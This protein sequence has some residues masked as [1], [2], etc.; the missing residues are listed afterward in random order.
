MAEDDGF[1]A[2]GDVSYFEDDETVE[3][4][5]CGTALFRRPHSPR[6]QVICLGCALAR[7]GELTI[8]PD[9]VTP[10][11]LADVKAVMRRDEQ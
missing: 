11:S 9:T 3:C 7:F 4:C 8:S 5:D 2:C 1:L 6:L 10:E